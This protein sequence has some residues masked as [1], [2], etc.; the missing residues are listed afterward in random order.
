MSS[1]GRI[2]AKP[3]KQLVFYHILV[4]FS[5]F[6]FYRCPTFVKHLP[7]NTPRKPTRVIL[8][9]PRSKI[10]DF[11]ESGLKSSISGGPGL[12]E[13]SICLETGPGS[14]QE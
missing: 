4:H 3:N 9:C 2:R 1:A 10:S 8:T 14:Q 11:Q 6:P 13:G 5:S 12:A 7:L